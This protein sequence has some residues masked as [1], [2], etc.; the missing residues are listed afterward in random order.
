MIV[1]DVTSIAK[2][3]KK[4]KKKKK[5]GLSHKLLPKT[6]SALLFSFFF[7]FFWN[8]Q[9]TECEKPF[10]YNFL[11][12]FFFSLSLSPGCC[13]P[14]FFL[15]SFFSLPFLKKKNKNWAQN[16]GVC[17]RSDSHVHAYR[18]MRQTF[19]FFFYAECNSP[20]SSCCDFQRCCC[21]TYVQLVLFPI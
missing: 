2:K 16:I 20:C 4:K 9:C 3:A 10:F 1:L 18:L 8:E 12:L 7:F 5:K 21:Y 13:E 19:F 6:V 17:S 11:G 15:I 14:F